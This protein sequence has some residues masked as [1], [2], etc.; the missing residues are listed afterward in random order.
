MF[1]HT[2]LLTGGTAGV[3]FLIHY[4]TGWNFGLV[5]FA[6]NLPFYGLAWKRMGKRFTLQ[7]VCRR[8]PDGGLQ[9][10]GAADGAVW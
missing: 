2:G 5:F 10:P 3:A 6:I 1:G 7:D 4:A 8:G 9:Q